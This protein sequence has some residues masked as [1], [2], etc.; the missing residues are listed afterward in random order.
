LWALGYDR[1][2][3]G[4]TN[5]IETFRDGRLPAAESVESVP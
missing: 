4:Y 5:L 3:P 1:G 2:V